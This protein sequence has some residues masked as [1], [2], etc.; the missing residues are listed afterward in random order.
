M[1]KKDNKTIVK[2]KLTK[3]HLLRLWPFT[4]KEKPVYNLKKMRIPRTS[5]RALKI[6][7]ILLRTPGFRVV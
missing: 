3:K 6:L 4:K 2:P 7:F 5:G 1:E